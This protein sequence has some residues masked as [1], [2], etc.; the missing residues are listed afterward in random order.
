M[1]TDQIRKLA[2]DLDDAVERGDIEM[3][4]SFFTGDLTERHRS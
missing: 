2:Q 3:V 4:V 1:P